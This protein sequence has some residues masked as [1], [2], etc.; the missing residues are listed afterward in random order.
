MAQWLG[1]GIGLGISH[2]GSKMKQGRGQKPP[3]IS[4]FDSNLLFHWSSGF[5]AY[6]I[7]TLICQRVVFAVSKASD[8]LLL[9]GYGW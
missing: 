8:V 6:I 5:S 3:D 7:V 4:V 2:S 9:S 1:I